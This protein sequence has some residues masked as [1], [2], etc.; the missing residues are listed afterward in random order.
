[1]KQLGVIEP[2]WGLSPQAGD[3]EKVE[4]KEWEAACREVYAAMVDRMDQGIGK[5]VAQ[6]ERDGQLDN[7][8]I[9]FLEDNGG[10]AEGVGR[11]GDKK[12]ADGP[13]LPPMDPAALQPRMV[14]KQ[15]RDGYPMLQGP[16]VLPGPA[17]TYIG[18]GRGWANVSN[19]PFREYKH[20][21]HEG[22][23]ST[24]LIAHWPAGISRKGELEHQPGH[25]IDLMATCVDVAGADYP[26]EYK[27]GRIQPMEGRSLAPAFRGGTIEREALYWEH[28][29]N[30]AVRVGKW[31]L[32]AK[33]RDGEWELYD[34]AADRSEMH[35]LAGEQ[36]DRVRRMA[37]LWQRYAERTGVI[38]W[39]K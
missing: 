34:T 7:T 36:P 3:W 6:L 33:S 11:R 13:T 32:V 1:M 19:T 27:G 9:L 12:R 29:G 23:I 18:Y 28:E 16:G 22:G 15:T 8:L 5:I 37:E 30:R 35:N 4:T 26:G 14:P 31:K 24:P 2:H 17:D 21:V 38:P 10:C 39:P 25:L 20:W